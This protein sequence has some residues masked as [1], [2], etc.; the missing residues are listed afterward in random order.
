MHVLHATVSNPRMPI[1]TPSELADQLFR[2][3]ETRAMQHGLRLGPGADSDLRAMADRAADTI[4]TAAVTKPSD[5]REHYVRGAARVA[6]EAM[7]TFVDEMTSARFRITG[8][9]EANPN[10]IG[11][12]TFQSARNVLCPLWPIC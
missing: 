9:A 4:L 3:A 6:T 7:M 10:V 2:A 1:P 8:Y 11:E 12:E 5:L